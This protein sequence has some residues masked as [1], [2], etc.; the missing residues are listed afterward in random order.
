MVELALFLLLFWFVEDEKTFVEHFVGIDI[1]S[2]FV[3][4]FGTCQLQH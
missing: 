3:F 2:L 1:A 4:M